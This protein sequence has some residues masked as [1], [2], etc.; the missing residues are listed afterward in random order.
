MVDLINVSYD[1][2]IPNNVGLSSDRK[3]LKALEKWHPGYINWWNDLIPEKFQKSMVYLRTAVSVD[4]KGW[5]KF[6]YVKMPEYRWGVLL[7]PQVEGRTIPCGEHY[8]QAAWQEVPGE[9]RNMLKRLIV[10]QGDTEPGSV[11]QQRFL[12]LTAPSLY[13][14]RNL[15]QV[16]VEEGRHL[17]AMVYLLQKYFGRDGREEANDLLVRSSGSEEAPRM[18]GA[19]NEETPDWLSFFMFTYFTD[20]DGKM[21]LESL[22]QSGFDPLSRT[23]RFMLTE[24]AHHMFVGETGVG[25]TIEKTCQVMRENGI[26]DPYDIDK[27]R[28]LGV[29]D[30]PT[31]QK[32]LNLHYTLSLDLFGQEVST[33]AANAFNAGIKGRFQEHRIDDDH[34]LKDATYTVWDFEDGK[35]VQK[36]VPALTAINMRLRDDYIKDAAGGVGRWNKIIEKAGVQFELKLPHESFNRKIGVFAG[37]NFDPDGKI[38]SGAE[39]D[40][41]IPNW[42]PTHAD[43]DFIQSLMVPVTEPGKFASWIAPP[44]VGIDNKPGDFEYVKLHMA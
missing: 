38:V 44:K 28:S 16:N 40:A 4:P 42:L 10:I 14:M 3:V 25:R 43:G 18:L 24:E 36:E 5:A 21:Q 7:A 20:R 12:G 33:N 13:D 31:I 29:I 2:Q 32:K 26:E 35:A 1:T 37:H 27:I 9:Y 41:G 17:W 8:G 6:D 30:L 39:Y 11:E 23:C 19:F 22:A 15:F 34:M